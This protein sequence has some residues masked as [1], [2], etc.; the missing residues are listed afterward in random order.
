MI[1]RPKYRFARHHLQKADLSDDQRNV[2]FDSEVHQ[3]VKKR[4]LESSIPDESELEADLA[5]DLVQRIPLSLN[6]SL[7]SKDESRRVDENN[8]NRDMNNNNIEGLECDLP[9]TH[10]LDK[11]VLPEAAITSEVIEA[12]LPCDLISSPLLPLSSTSFSNSLNVAVQV[13]DSAIES[14]CMLLADIPHQ[15][16][17]G[18]DINEAQNNVRDSDI[19]AETG[20]IS[21]VDNYDGTLQP[22]AAK[23]SEVSNVNQNKT[24][25]IEF[26][27]GQ[28]GNQTHEHNQVVEKPLMDFLSDETEE[29]PFVTQIMSAA[30][31]D[32]KSYATFCENHSDTLNIT[33][34]QEYQ[35]IPEYIFSFK[36]PL[37]EF[38]AI[39]LGMLRDVVD[40]HTALQNNGT[41]N[42]ILPEL[43]ANLPR[44]LRNNVDICS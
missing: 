35:R 30:P 29:N 27:S 1:C 6:K 34:L 7:K 13:E 19:S 12:N 32:T 4:K 37:S 28:P 24:Q 11:N 10:E 41:G 16:S 44:N 42:F 3:K 21:S 18:K 5:S 17:D 39:L 36:S 43:Y 14:E 33:K 40:L 20:T 22:L 23:S 9:M 38:R 2:D 26:L 25:S 15:E 31:S 8:F